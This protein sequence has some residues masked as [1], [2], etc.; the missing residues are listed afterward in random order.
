MWVLLLISL[1]VYVAAAIFYFKA[2]NT[3]E[4]AQT[5][6]R[7]TASAVAMRLLN[8]SGINN[9]II[10]KTDKGK[11]NYY[12][13]YANT[14]RLSKDVHASKKIAD[15]LLACR[16]AEFAIQY[17]EG[18][19][20]IKLREKAGPIINIVYKFAL[21]LAIIFLICSLN[22]L[23]CVFMV[24]FLGC[25][26]SKI[27]C[28]PAERKTNIKVTEFVQQNALFSNTIGLGETPQKVLA[29]I[30]ATDL[31]SCASPL[32]WMQKIK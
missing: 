24:V 20:I 11:N 14:V 13:V 3:V 22:G 30:A 25:T 23:G 15:V 1:A 31:H 29:A 6:G 10:D 26:V 32:Y 27:I 19:G 8:E 12:D 2:R 4:A 21:W 5:T 17:Q 7:D 16:E 28:I 18:N 9:M